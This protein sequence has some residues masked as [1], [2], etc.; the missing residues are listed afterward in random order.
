MPAE[1]ETGAALTVSD[2]YSRRVDRLRFVLPAIALLLL[3]VVMV[4]PWVVGGYGGFIVPIFKNAVDYAGDAMRMANP[5][6]VGQTKDLDSYEV[7]ASSAILDPT[8]PDRIHLD[9][10]DAVFE[11]VGSSAVR[12]R[13]NEG[14]YSRKQSLLELDGALELTFGESGDDGRGYRFETESADVDLGR[15][16]VIGQDPVTGDGPVGTLAAERFNIRDGG[17]HLRFEGAVQVIIWPGEPAT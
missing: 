6:Y 13:A 11:Q 9:Q 7:T 10:L 15:G 12:L 14:V 17:K 16:E 2:R 4:W 5:R 1:V 8:N 3:A